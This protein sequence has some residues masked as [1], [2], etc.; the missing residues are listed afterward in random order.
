MLTRIANVQIFDPANGIDGEIRDLCLRDGKIVPTSIDQNSARVIDATGLIAMPG[1]IDMHTHVAGPAVNVARGLTI[2]S[3]RNAPPLMRTTFGRSGTTGIIPSSYAVGHLYTALGYTTVV[4]AAIPP[5]AARG[6]HLE[7]QCIPGPEKGFLAL[8]GN[9]PYLLAAIQSGN[10]E[11]VRATCGWLVESSGSLG[12]KVVN[13]GGVA[14]WC[15]GKEGLLGIDDAVSAYGVTPRDIIRH[16]AGAMDDLKLPHPMH[17]HCNRLG[18]PGNWATT[19]ESMKAAEGRRTHLTHIQFHSYGGDAD[20]QTSFCSKVQPLVEYL[21]AHPELTVDVGQV[22]FGDAVSLTG[23]LPTAEHL[24]DLLRIARY[25]MHS[26]CDGGCGVMQIKYKDK[27]LVH[28]TQCAIGLEWFLLTANLWQVAMSTDHPNGG[29][30]RSYPEIIALLMS[31]ALRQELLATLPSGVLERSVLRDITR[32]LSLYE[33]AI[34]TRAAPARMLGLSTKGHLGEGAEADITLY[35]PHHDKRV[36]FSTPHSVF[37]S[38]KLVFDRGSMLDLPVSPVL[39][40]ARDYD[41]D[42]LGDVGE[43]IQQAHCISPPNYGVD[44]AFFEES[45]RLLV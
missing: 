14:N 13:P 7:L 6:V 43:W 28:A 19:L 34:I 33:I 20:D 38:G 27:S 41:R 2:A 8:A 26:G 24:A 10:L 4:D 22:M 17:L 30:F 9:H 25:S 15:D 45:G 16:I 44:S 18:L 23:D 35:Q 36:M 42:A 3:S 21:N 40:A 29:A 37:K 5:V 1:G 39:C 31:N 11:R 32:E 12:L